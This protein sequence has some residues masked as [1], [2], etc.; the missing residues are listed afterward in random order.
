MHTSLLKDRML[1]AQN[2]A[3]YYGYGKVEELSLFDLAIIEP[4]GLEIEELNQIKARNTVIITYLSLLEVHPTESI[5][6]ELT[7]DD[8]IMLDGEPFKNEAFETYLVNLHS[9]TWINYLLKEIHFRFQIL[10]ADGLFLDTIGDL[11]FSTIPLNIKEKQLMALTNF[12]SILKMLYPTRLI[13][14]NNGLETVCQQTAPYIDGICW[15]NPP[16]S[17]PES[18]EWVDLIVQRLA[19]LKN[20]YQL[21]IFLLLEETIEKERNT[22]TKAKKMAKEQGFLLYNAPSKYVT[23]VNI[24]KD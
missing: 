14:Q 13:I 7:N 4:K 5:F 1:I 6:Q 22:Y 12:L 3:L 8:F 23:D 15:E 16:L 10:E 2:Y 21:K 18:K 17:L 11:E 20:E 9:K 19:K 24:I